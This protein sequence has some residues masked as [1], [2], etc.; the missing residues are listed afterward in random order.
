M[1]NHVVLGQRE[2]KPIDI[3]ES[4]RWSS[5]IL[6]SQ[7][8]ASESTSPTAH[9]KVFCCTILGRTV[10]CL[11]VVNIKDFATTRWRSP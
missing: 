10:H 5:E 4:D 3:T 8:T 7:A 2:S 6:Q 11:F 1:R 9:S